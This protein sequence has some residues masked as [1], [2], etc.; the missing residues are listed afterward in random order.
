MCAPRMASAAG[1]LRSDGAARSFDT[2]TNAA[3]A[4]RSPLQSLLCKSS[5]Q[6]AGHTPP[7]RARV[8]LFL[9]LLFCFFP[10][11]HCPS[12]YLPWVGTHF[13]RAMTTVNIV[14]GSLFPLL[15]ALVLL[16]PQAAQS[17]IQLD[18]TCAFGTDYIQLVGFACIEAEEKARDPNYTGLWADRG[19]H[20]VKAFTLINRNMN[21]IGIHVG[22][23]TYCSNFTVRQLSGRAVL[24]PP[25]TAAAASHRA[26]HLLPPHPGPLS[27]LRYPFL[28]LYCSRSP[29]V[30]LPKLLTIATCLLAISDLSLN[31]C[32][33]S[34]RLVSRA[35]VCARVC[36]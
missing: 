24:N 6:L 19:R 1:A 13:F 26:R 20:N 10:S 11:R 5:L 15:L 17:E 9:L 16:L 27:P 35:C 21:R 3:L 12:F 2:P 33:L 22:N 32:S 28:A 4:P 30:S 36:E 18:N 29:I 8:L 25:A 14:R 23:I 31:L 34:L 7:A